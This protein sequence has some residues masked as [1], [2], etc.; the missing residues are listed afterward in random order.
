MD[1]VRGCLVL[2]FPGALFNEALIKLL[3]FFACMRSFASERE[4]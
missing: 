3:L 4:S 2:A 1:V